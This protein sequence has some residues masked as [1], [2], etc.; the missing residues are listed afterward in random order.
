MSDDRYRSVTET[1]IDAII[2][3]DANNS[4]LTWNKGAETIFGYDSEAIGSSVTAIIPEKYR[5]AHSNGVRRFLETGEK[6]LIG[7]SIELEAMR[8]DGTVFPVE[9]SLS[10]WDSSDGVNFGA[11]IRDISERKSIEKVKE[12]VQNI[13]RHDI[14]SPLAGIIGLARVLQKNSKLKEK[15]KKAATLIQELGEKTLKFIDRTRDLFQMEQ[16]VYKLKLENVNIC[17]IIKDISDA[18]K[19]IFL[20]KEINFNIDINGKGFQRDSEYLVKG[21][22]GLLEMMLAN[23]IRNAIDASPKK[24]TISVSINLRKRN[25]RSFHLI[26]IHNLGVVPQDMREKFF[27]PYSTSGKKGGTGLGTYSAL[28]VAKAHNGNIYFT[29]SE[30]KGTNVIIEL[31]AEINQDR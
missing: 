23:L 26:D 25:R 30:E 2:T 12:D 8:K 6:R 24:A 15:Q 17:E 20:K 18:F 1:S 7:K 22:Y 9:L 28:L 19:P 29:T 4:I 31:S 13:M 16:G 27:E 10:T 21:D 14:R 5:E 3:T 11:I